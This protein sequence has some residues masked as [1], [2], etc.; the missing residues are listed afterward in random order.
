MSERFK[1]FFSSGEFKNES[2]SE[3]S[4]QVALEIFPD[5]LNME[6]WVE[7]HNILGRIESEH[8]KEDAGW[9]GKLMCSTVLPSQS[10]CSNLVCSKT[11]VHAVYTTVTVLA[12]LR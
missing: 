8:L 5:H 10:A 11:C 2:T 1:S 4:T 12:L 6:I 7:A 9:F 3:N